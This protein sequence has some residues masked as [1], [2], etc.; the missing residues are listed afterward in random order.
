MDL[1]SSDTAEAGSP[2]CRHQIRRTLLQPVT[3]R[4]LVWRIIGSPMTCIMW[5]DLGLL[6]VVVDKDVGTT[7]QI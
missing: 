6:I 4:R 3:L 5:E 1:I 7:N 2:A